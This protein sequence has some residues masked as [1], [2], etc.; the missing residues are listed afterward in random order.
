M[1][2]PDAMG[3]TQGYG[4]QISVMIC[5][6]SQVQLRILTQA[7]ED[8][9]YLVHAAHSAEEVLALLQLMPT[10][11][12]LTGIEI[13]AV[14]GLEVCWSLKA[15]AETESIHTIV[16]TA[17]GQERR[18]EESLDAGADDFIRKP[19]NMTELRARL[20]AASRLVR[21][22]KQ[23]RQ[24][25]ETDSLTSA[26]NRRAFMHCLEMETEQARRHGSAVSVV[27]I[28][29]DHFKHVND[30]HGHAIGDRV[31]IE[32]VKAVQQC[33][34][35]RDMLGRLG[36]EEFAVVLHGATIEQAALAAERIRCAVEAMDIRNDA[37]EAVP[38]TTSLG[39]SSATA[40]TGLDT[41]ESLLLAADEALY[42]AKHSG[43]NRVVLAGV[44]APERLG[45]AG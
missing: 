12:L 42:E 37:G 38:V 10:D 16:I 14:S 18:L 15:D 5:E 39:V 7:V 27:M 33:L 40:D 24:L 31:L 17:S 34:R 9:G 32:T 41:P 28:D 1:T 36:G 8:A 35:D 44:R 11:I 45:A 2:G 6:S 21:M 29:L 22:Q 19:V 3:D 4:D 20:R 26:A 30:T 25:A 23:F 13:G 43:R